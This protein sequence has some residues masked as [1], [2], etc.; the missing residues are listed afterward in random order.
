MGLTAK[1]YNYSEWRV[2]FHS[3]STV[4]FFN[5]YA[6]KLSDLFKEQNAKVNF[7]MIGACDGTSDNTIK[8]L[9]LKN[10]HWRGV[11]VEPLTMNVRDLIK[12]MAK[13]EAQSRSLIIHAAATSECERPTIVMER[14]LYEEKNASIPHW[15]RRQIGSILPENRDHARKEWT[16]EE[17]RCVTPSDVLSD[18]SSQT[19]KGGLVSKQQQDMNGEIVASAGGKVKKR[20][21]PHVLKI[22]VE[23]H[24]FEVLTGFLRLDT[25][26][27]EL[28][29]LI[30]FEAKSIAKKY[31]LAK[32][33]MEQLGYIVSPFG[34]D[35]FAILHADRILASIKTFPSIKATQP[36]AQQ[37]EKSGYVSEV[38]NKRVNLRQ[39]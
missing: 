4:D 8:N 23:G 3:K 39:A 10:D 11:F 31:P 24:D 13:H 14:P 15:L 16:T 37:A 30:D 22:D 28:P 35:G 19:K 38:S 29:L 27:E 7:A 5:G 9:Y 17:V 36:V 18:W 21:R 26:L 2:T 34:Q 32:E 33:R 20:R 12:F 1:D 25:P 6:K